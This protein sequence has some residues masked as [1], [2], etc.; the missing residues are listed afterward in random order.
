MSAKRN[1]I[2]ELRLALSNLTETWSRLSRS[3]MVSSSV[4]GAG[5]GSSSSTF[6]ELTE[7]SF[8]EQLHHYV[9]TLRAC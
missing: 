5:G 4:D 8:L 1:K 7:N 2:V 6:N 9:M 3:R